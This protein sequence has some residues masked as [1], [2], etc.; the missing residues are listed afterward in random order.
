MKGKEEGGGIGASGCLA[1]GEMGSDGLKDARA[2][3]TERCWN[4]L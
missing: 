1:W 2:S 3:D 4:E